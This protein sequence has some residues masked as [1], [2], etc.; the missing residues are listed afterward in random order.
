M[1]D[2]ENVTW[3]QFKIADLFQVEKCK[4]KLKKDKLLPYSQELFP[5]YSSD[6]GNHG[7]V[8]YIK[9]NPSFNLENN[10]YMVVFGDHTRAINIVKKSFSICDNV[11]ILSNPNNFS[12]EIA[13]FIITAW[14]KAI[15][16]LGYNRHWKK[17]SEVDISLPI[18][19]T[20]DPD[21]DFMEDFIKELKQEHIED[22]EQEKITEEANYLQVTGLSDTKLTKAEQKALD[23]FDSLTWA[24]FK[25]GELFDKATRGKRLKKADQKTGNIPFVTAGTNNTGIV[26]NIANPIQKSEGNVISIDMFGNVFYRGYEFGF[27]DNICV[28]QHSMN[29]Y[30]KNIN[31]F[32][33]SC[34][35]KVLIGKFDYSYQYRHSKSENI[36]VKLP[37][38]PSDPTKPDYQYMETYI[39]AIEKLTIK[40]VVDLK[41]EQI[42]TTKKV[43]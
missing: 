18:L 30:T 8:G 33:V 22:L 9:E 3:G 2:L 7:V 16:D 24:D 29:N 31:L 38:D 4:N 40:D 11:K 14:K 32:L 37:L 21:Y 10:K 15:P 26:G 43:V 23:D 5:V 25:I 39:K 1:A 13:L 19:P 42:A 36:C 27:D 12:L 28:Y 6:S 34:L 41:D 20:G 17:A 35:S